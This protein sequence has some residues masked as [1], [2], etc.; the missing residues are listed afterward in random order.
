MKCASRF[1]AES[2]SGREQNSDDSLYGQVEMNDGR[3]VFR[4]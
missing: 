2:E 3:S 1:A 4:I